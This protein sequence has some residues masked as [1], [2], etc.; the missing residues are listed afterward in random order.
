[1]KDRVTLTTR[2]QKRVLVRQR[3]ERGAMTAAEVATVLAVSVRQVR[4]LLAAY[5]QE[6]VAALA[7]GHRGRTPV[8]T[9]L[10]QVR[11]QVLARTTTHYAGANVQH[12]RGAHARGGA[13]ARDGIAVVVLGHRDAR[14]VQHDTQALAILHAVTPS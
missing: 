8:H 4:R 11:Q 3:M 14:R 12:L 10:P 1:M 13:H 7:H 2:K 6:R 5:R 9:I